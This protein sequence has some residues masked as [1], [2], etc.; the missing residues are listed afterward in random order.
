MNINEASKM[1]LSYVDHTKNLSHLTVKAYQQ[2]I[3]LF[4][5]LLGNDA[6]LASISRL[7]IR[8]VVNALFAKGQSKSTVKRRVACYKSMFSWFETEE[9]IEQTPFHKLDVKIKLPHRLPSNLSSEEL[10]NL[11]DTSLANIGIDS[12]ETVDF[13]LLPKK[14][15]NHLTVFV[16]IELLLTTGL[17]ISE[18]TNIK[19]ND[20][21]LSESHI[22]IN[23]K[24]QRERRVFITTKHIKKLLQQYV[25]IRK[26]IT[27][28]HEFLLINKQGKP[29]TPQTFRL[30]LNGLSEKAK[31]KR[32]VT[33]H[34]YRHS[35]ATKLL[36]AGVD[37][38]YV[39]KLLGHQ[40]ISTTQIYTHVNNTNLYEAIVAAN[41]QG[42]FL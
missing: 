7:E 19:L 33:P 1:Y 18:L 2:D 26:L 38:R 34:M 31:I 36:E 35:A 37:I 6:Q 13:S 12:F 17:R 42:E 3:N 40:N 29:A 4:L 25:Q 24:G 41:V 22:N 20:I 16:G 39:Q 14:S 21:Y 15:I 11:R 27:N 5:E 30:W 28:D 10:K 9:L 8:M 23:G 32:K